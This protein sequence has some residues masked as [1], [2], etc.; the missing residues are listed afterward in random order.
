VGG[1]EK[2]HL[3]ELVKKIEK[4]KNNEIDHLKVPREGNVAGGCE[5]RGS[6]RRRGC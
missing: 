1:W 3:K 4:K 6:S 2:G 5:V